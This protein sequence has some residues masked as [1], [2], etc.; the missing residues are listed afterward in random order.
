MLKNFPLDKI[1]VTKNDLICT[2]VVSLKVC[3]G[4]SN[5]DSFLF[6]LKFYISVQ[7]KAWTL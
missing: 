7:Q 1:N 6:L 4:F 5:F 2:R 3:V